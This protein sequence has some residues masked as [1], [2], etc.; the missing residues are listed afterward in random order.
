MYSAWTH[1]VIDPL[2]P[3]WEDGVVLFGFPIVLD[4]VGDCLFGKANLVEHDV[5]VT[6]SLSCDTDSEEVLG[7][8][9]VSY[10]VVLQNVLLKLVCE[11]FASKEEDVVDVNRDDEGVSYPAYLSIEDECVRIG[12]SMFK[13]EVLHGGAKV[14]VPL[15][16]GLLQAIEGFC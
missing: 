11:G 16:T 7:V 10:V 12:L 14:F 15:V 5:L 1:W 2:P 9:G 8:A 6:C 13:T 4:Y 3:V